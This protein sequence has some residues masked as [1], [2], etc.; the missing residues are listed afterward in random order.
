MDFSGTEQDK[1]SDAT[2][3]MENTHRERDHVRN[4]STQEE[5]GKI[6]GKKYVN[7]CNIRRQIVKKSDLLLNL[8]VFAGVTLKLRFWRR[9]LSILFFPSPPLVVPSS[10]GKS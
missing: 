10:F 4:Y 6:P 8:A 3:R 5:R 1:I 2:L 7:S 9:S